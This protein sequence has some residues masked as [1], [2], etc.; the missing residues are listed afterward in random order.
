MKNDGNNK[1]LNKED[2]NKKGYMISVK[3]SRKKVYLYN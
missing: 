3:T 2:N 1:R